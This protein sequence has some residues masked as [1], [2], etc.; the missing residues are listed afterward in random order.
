M[1]KLLLF[2]GILI[3]VIGAIAIINVLEGCP[4]WEI[5][6]TVFM[7]YIA[8]GVWLIVLDKFLKL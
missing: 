3:A 4:P 5:R 8:V 2:V 1:K 7:H 6:Q